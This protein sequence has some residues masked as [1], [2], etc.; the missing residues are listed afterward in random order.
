MTITPQPNYSDIE[1]MRQSVRE[2]SDDL[3]ALMDQCLNMLESLQRDNAE[4]LKDKE[5][6]SWLITQGPP[7]ASQ[8]DWLSE[9]AWE[10]ATC[11]VEDD[12]HDQECMRKAIDAARKQTRRMPL[13]KPDHPA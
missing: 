1:Q 8:I 9:D 13:A 7:G 6:L 4:L 3:P 11:Q 10:L 12:S 5:R 2:N